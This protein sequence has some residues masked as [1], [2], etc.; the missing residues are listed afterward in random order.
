MTQLFF[1]E[2]REPM[3]K[4]ILTLIL[5]A[6]LVGLSAC[7]STDPGPANG[8]VLAPLPTTDPGL[9]TLT[10]LIAEDPNLV[11][12]MSGLNAVGLTDDLQNNGP[13]TVFAASNVAFSA[14]G[15]I[16][17]QM[18]PAL[19]GQIMDNHLADGASS[20]EEL[21]GTGS[22]VTLVGETLTI[23]QEGEGIKVDYAPLVTEAKQASNGTLFV[24]DTLLLPPETGPEKSMWGVLQ[25][26]R[27]F[28]NLYHHHG[29]HR[30]DGK[31]A[32]WRSI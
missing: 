26:R 15:L 16:V 14:A 24:I 1:E 3:L 13:F 12:F 5:L 8:D 9:A 10:E 17:S 22:V 18:E 32:F 4:R 28:H 20:V 25:S 31:P 2:K 29:R 27:P 19:L 7:T 30:H 11:F 21:L 6:L 23:T